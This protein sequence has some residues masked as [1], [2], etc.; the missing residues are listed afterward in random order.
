MAD[1]PG[2]FDSLVGSSV[3]EDAQ[4]DAQIAQNFGKSAIGSMAFGLGQ[5]AGGGLGIGVAGLFGKSQQAKDNLIANANGITANEVRTRRRLRTEL[6]QKELVDDG[7]FSA[8]RK[9]AQMAA[10]IANEEGDSV[11]LARALSAVTYVDREEQ[12]WKK[13]QATTK[14]AQ[15]KAVDDQINT[16]YTSEGEPLTGIPAIKD[17]VAGMNVTVG[18]K[19]VFKPF[20][21]DFSEV[22][23][24]KVNSL[25]PQDIA[26][27]IKINRGTTTITK[28]AGL[29]SSAN[30]ALAKTDRVL[31]TLNDLYE[32]GG[33]ESVIGTSGRI[34]STVDNLVKNVNGVINAFAARGRAEDAKPKV[35]RDGTV[36]RSFAGVD[37]LKEFAQD[38]GNSFSQLIQLPEGIEATSAA[39]QQH[40][41]AVMEMAYM[42]ARLAEPSNRGLSD[43]DIKNALARIAGDTSNPQVMMRRFIEMQVD[44]A[45]E[46][47]YELRLI[48][49]SLGP[50]ISDDAINMALVGKGYAEYKT[51]KDELFDKF[52][53]TVGSDGRATFA[54]GTSI[55]A[56]VQPGEGTGVVPEEDNIDY[57]AMSNEEAAEAL[58]L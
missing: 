52:N 47:D 13:L 43:N 4:Y 8:R 28:I 53:V 44:A 54:E 25:L 50:N 3:T 16:G 18:G 38:A 23:P 30:T 12:E 6:A 46:L 39:A 15:G 27:Q 5:M 22:A 14:S 9:M 49:G 57:E 51:R 10:K 7:T 55:G 17:G 45:G 42:A 40:R 48:H 2:F 24:D 58:G 35:A 19:L 26:H 32:N 1:K 33:V 21:E 29:A 11:G 20:D 41:A 36:I 56:D 34:I 37:G 31:S